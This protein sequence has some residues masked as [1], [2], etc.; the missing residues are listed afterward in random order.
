M[1]R[2]PPPLVEYQTVLRGDLSGV[3]PQSDPNRV[4]ERLTDFQK[5]ILQRV[6]NVQHRHETRNYNT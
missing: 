4:I 6:S 1:L 5:G 2:P 3:H